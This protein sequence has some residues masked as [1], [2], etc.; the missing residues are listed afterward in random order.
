VQGL[1]RELA[2]RVSKTDYDL[3]LRSILQIPSKI[4]FEDFFKIFSN[5]MEHFD[6]K[7][8]DYTK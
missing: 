6:A 1:E 7:N 4:E 3:M 8:R 2:T 5:H